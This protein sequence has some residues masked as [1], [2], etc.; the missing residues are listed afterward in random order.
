MSDQEESI[1][2]SQYFENLANESKEP[3]IVETSIENNTENWSKPLKENQPARKRKNVYRPV[4]SKAKKR[5]V[6]TV[7]KRHRPATPRK[8]TKKRKTVHHNF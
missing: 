5:T 3:V 1:D 4:K 7:T 2:F 6:K 8:S